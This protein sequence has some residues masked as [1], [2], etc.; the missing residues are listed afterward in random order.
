MTTLPF[1]PH[2]GWES[3]VKWSFGLAG[4]STIYF[5]RARTEERHLSKDPKYV[6]YA[7]WMNEHGWL[8]FLN[9]IP[10]IKYKAPV[11]R[12]EAKAA[13]PTPPPAAPDAVQS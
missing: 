1:I 8:R 5:L 6:E 12:E 9:R 7:L 4:V 3:A 10:G 13:G 2:H 11:G